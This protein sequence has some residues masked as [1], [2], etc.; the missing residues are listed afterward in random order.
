MLQ[1]Q[2]GTRLRSDSSSAEFIVVRASS[3]AVVLSCAGGPL[4]PTDEATD[5][6]VDENPDM[7]VGK[8]F[9]HDSG[10]ELLCVRAGRGPL[11]VD[12]QPLTSRSA[13]ALPSSD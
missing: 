6:P 8:R 4:T 13:K 9:G 12:G 10:I 3:E 2:P 1:L 11:E 7:T 5:T